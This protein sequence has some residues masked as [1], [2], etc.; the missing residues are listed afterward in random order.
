MHRPQRTASEAVGPGILAGSAADVI[1]G[2][3][4]ALQPGTGDYIAGA[5]DGAGDGSR[6]GWRLLHLAGAVRDV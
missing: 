4:L 5:I 2:L 6:R 1:A 3:T